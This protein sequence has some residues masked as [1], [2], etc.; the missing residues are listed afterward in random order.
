MCRSV[1]PCVGSSSS[2]ATSSAETPIR[3]H[4][5]VAPVSSPSPVASHGLADGWGAEAALRGRVPTF[6]TT[7]VAP[8]GTKVPAGG[9]FATGAITPGGSVPGSTGARTAPLTAGVQPVSGDGA[10]GRFT[11]ACG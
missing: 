11:V 3:P 8:V 5:G 7:G 10:W 4:A 9:V 2:S 6:A 1:Y